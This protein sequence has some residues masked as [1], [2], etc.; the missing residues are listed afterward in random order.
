MLEIVCQIADLVRLIM[1]SEE[2]SHKLGFCGAH[3]NWQNVSTLGQKAIKSAALAHLAY[4]SG[5]IKIHI[6]II[7]GG[8]EINVENHNAQKE[9]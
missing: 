5:L 2:N 8:L 4:R 7:A 3:Q 6:W 1:Q 9:D